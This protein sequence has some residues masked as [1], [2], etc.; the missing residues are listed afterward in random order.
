MGGK[1]ALAVCSDKSLS[2]GITIEDIDSGA[3][4]LHIPTS[5]SPSHGLTCLASQCLVASQ[6]HR[7]GSVAGGVIF[8]WPLNKPQAPVR[9][10]PTEAIGP[11]ACTRDGVFLVGGAPSGNAYVWEVSSGRLLR[12]WC[13]HHKSLTCLTFSGDD[14]FLISGSEDGMIIV[15]PMIGL[16]D[17]TDRWNLPSVLTFSSEH[18]SSITGVLTTSS[19]SSS[20]FMSSSLDGTCKVWDL[21][22]GRLLQTQ[23]FPLPMTAIVLDPAEKMLFCGSADGRIFVNTLDIGLVEAASIVSEDEPMVLKGHNGSITALTFCGLGLISA[24][25]DCTACLWDVVNCPI[26]NLVV[27]PQSSLLPSMNHHRA[28]NQFRVSILD[29]YPKPPD[30]SN[31]VLTLL[32]SHSPSEDH[33]VASEY[34]STNLLKQQFLDLEKEGTFASMQ[35]KAETS[36][37][38]QAWATRMTRHVMQMNKHLQSR[39]LDMMQRRLLQQP[40]NASSTTNN[41]KRKKTNGGS[42]PLQG[43]EQPQS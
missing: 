14:S 13:A 22:T 29:K 33:C 30:A 27:I 17:E 6:I 4:L 39:L 11:I 18:S 31:G 12:T 8:I 28:P 5:A 15:W 9:S 32:P 26:T 1:E 40:P 24:S 3:H 34:R 16:L 7:Q 37:E 19:S 10:Y 42:L 43:E 20:V 21:V 41:R 23:V 25:E 38:S 2:I 36:I 35:M